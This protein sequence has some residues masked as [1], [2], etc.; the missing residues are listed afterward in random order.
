MGLQPDRVADVVA[1]VRLLA[2]VGGQAEHRQVDL[3]HRQAGPEDLERPR[4][5][6]CHRL[7]GGPLGGARLADDERPLE[8]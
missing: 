8:L 5:E 6:R 3:G 1:Q 7:E 2:E 4:L